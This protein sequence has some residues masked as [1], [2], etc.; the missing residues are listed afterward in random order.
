MVVPV[1]FIIIIIIIIIIPLFEF[2]LYQPF[3]WWF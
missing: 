1:L 3:Y 2:G